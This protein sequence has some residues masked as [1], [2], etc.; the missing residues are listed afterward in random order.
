MYICVANF[1]L[2]GPCT[3]L[4]HIVGL[5]NVLCLNRLS[6]LACGDN[7]AHV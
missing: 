1:P 4:M 5:Y 2:R 3:L 6:M 7:A